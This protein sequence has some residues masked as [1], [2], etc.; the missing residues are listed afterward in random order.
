MAASVTD[1]IIYSGILSTKQSR[2][3][4]CDEQRTHYYLQFEACLAKVQAQLGI[5]PPKAAVA[6]A[7]KC[8]LTNIDFATLRE[9][10][11]KIGYPVLPVV[12]QLVAA[13]NAGEAGLGEWAHYGATTQDSEWATPY[14]TVDPLWQSR[15]GKDHGSRLWAFGG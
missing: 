10:T 7:Q 11:E 5:I 9:E 6:I 3:I 4:W 15:I 8:T 1:S 14:S 2:M 12:K 13:V